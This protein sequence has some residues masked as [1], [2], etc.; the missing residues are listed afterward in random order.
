LYKYRLN[1]FVLIN[2][3]IFIYMMKDFEFFNDEWNETCIEKS[4]SIVS[5]MEGVIENSTTAEE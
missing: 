2:F 4:N 5:G 1:L 3:R